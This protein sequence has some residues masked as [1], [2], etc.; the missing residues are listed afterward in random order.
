MLKSE[1]DRSQ[2]IFAFRCVQCC[3]QFKRSDLLVNIKTEHLHCPICKSLVR[4]LKGDETIES[5]GEYD[6]NP[7]YDGDQV[8]C[9]PD[10]K[11]SVYERFCKWCIGRGGSI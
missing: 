3:H 5:W 11:L 1:M 7:D 6:D 8:Y 2:R 9:K 10:A 4:Q